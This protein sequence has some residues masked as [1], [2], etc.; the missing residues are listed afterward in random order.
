MEYA[1]AVGEVQQQSARGRHDEKTRHG[2]AERRGRA[3]FLQA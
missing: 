3:W 2:H 1:V